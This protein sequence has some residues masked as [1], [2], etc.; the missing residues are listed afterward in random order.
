MAQIWREPYTVE[1]ARAAGIH[2][3]EGSPLLGEPGESEWIVYVTVCGFTF[4]FF[5]E[6]MLRQYIDYYSRKTLP[7][8]RFHGV[9]PFSNGPAASIG[10]GQ[11]PF[12]RLPGELRKESKRLR[13]VKALERALASFAD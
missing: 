4:A 1:R 2:G 3:H 11:S 12:E 6:A 13:V 7:T 8:T 10:D 5:S 9:S